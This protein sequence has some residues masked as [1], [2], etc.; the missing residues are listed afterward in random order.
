MTWPLVLA[1][2]SEIPG[3]LDDP[4]LQAWQV[5]WIGHAVLHQPLHLFQANSSW[6]LLDSLAFTDVL[7]GYAPAGLI[8]Q[9]GP[10]EAVV[11][12]DLLFLF[13]YALAFTGAYLLGRELRLSQL[14][15]FVSGVAFAYA[16]WRLTHNGHLNVLSSGA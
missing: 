15:A 4:L 3:D 5:A 9:G 14:A 12:Y 2:G 8:A 1:I 6:P 13:V 10:H 7:V 16:P 11:V